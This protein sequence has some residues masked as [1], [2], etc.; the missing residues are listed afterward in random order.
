MVQLSRPYMTTWKTMALTIW[1]FV[2]RVMSLFFSTL[3]RIVIAFLP[4]SKCLI[5]WL[6]SPSAVILDPKKRK[7]H[8]FHLFLI[9]LPWSKGAGCHN[10][11]FV[12]YLNTY[13]MAQ[14]FLYQIFTWSNWKHLSKKDVYV[15]VFTSSLHKSIHIIECYSLKGTYNMINFKNLLNKRNQ[16]QKTKCCMISFICNSRICKTV[17]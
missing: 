9:Y 5:S 6:Q 8:Y 3:S 11:S 12:Q 1:T 17:E 2:G 16:M 7:S 10:L 4:R 15:N 13:H 14:Q